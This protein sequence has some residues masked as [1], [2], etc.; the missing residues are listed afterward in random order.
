MSELG[1]N[2]FYPNAP[3]LS[4]DE[5]AKYST[6]LFDEWA[7]RLADNLEPPDYSITLQDMQGSREGLA[8]VGVVA[9]KVAT[10]VVAYGGLVAGLDA[11]RK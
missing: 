6:R 4:R 7:A 9:A 1:A 8:I 10:G 2:S 3:V 11:I 5:L